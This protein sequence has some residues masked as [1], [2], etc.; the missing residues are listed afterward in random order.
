MQALES[1]AIERSRRET[2]SLLHGFLDVRATTDNSLSVEQSE[3]I[4]TT[5]VNKDREEGVSNSAIDT[6][7]RVGRRLAIVG[8]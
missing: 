1:Q 3:I 6:A 5:I 4:V 7:A 8:K 2:E